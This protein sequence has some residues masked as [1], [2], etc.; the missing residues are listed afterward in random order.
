M[1]VPLI[2]G[3]LESDE[4]E[5]TDRI[6][7]GYERLSDIYSIHRQEVSTRQPTDMDVVGS[8]MEWERETMNPHLDVEYEDVIENDKS[9][10]RYESAGGGE[11]S[12]SSNTWNA[13]RTISCRSDA[14]WSSIVSGLITQ[15]EV[16]GQG[17][18]QCERDVAVTAKVNS[19]Q[20]MLVMVRPYLPSARF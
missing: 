20:A 7:N 12:T 3:R 9:S 6:A 19:N 4:K 10:R 1:A 11:S 16:A 18:D 15:L 14:S 2:Y 13:S 8:E 5:C 17:A